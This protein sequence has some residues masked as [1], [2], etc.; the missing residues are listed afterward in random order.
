MQSLYKHQNTRYRS[1]LICLRNKNKRW[2]RSFSS[3]NSFFNRSRISLTMLLPSQRFH[4]K[5]PTASMFAVN[6]SSF[7]NIRHRVVPSFPSNFG[8]LICT[9]PSSSD[10]HSYSALTGR[11]VSMSSTVRFLDVSRCVFVFGKY[12]P[13]WDIKQE[14]GDEQPKQESGE[15]GW[16][17]KDR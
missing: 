15:H 2:S 6:T 1:C 4:T 10:H 11:K 13:Q 3:E 7:L 8:T 17:V 12:F 16:K 9:I 14:K 5:D